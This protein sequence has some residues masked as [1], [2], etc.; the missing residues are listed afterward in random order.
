MFF[1]VSVTIQYKRCCASFACASL[2][3]GDFAFCGFVG[4]ICANISL[5]D[6]PHAVSSCGVLQVGQF[7]CVTYTHYVYKMY[8]CMLYNMHLHCI[9][10]CINF[11][12]TIGVA[13]CCL[14]MSI[15]KQ[16]CDK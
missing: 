7:F 5:F 4:V 1:C 9:T 13:C 3:G 10:L 6:L 15:V 16:I 2:G 11:E 8:F 14:G 12:M